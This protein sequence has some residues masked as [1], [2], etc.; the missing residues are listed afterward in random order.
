MLAPGSQLDRFEILGLLGAGG[1][2]E[3]YRAHDSRLR[4]DVA[5]KLLPENF[6]RNAERR[7]RFERETQV[8]ASLNHPNI[9]ALYEIVAVPGS[10]ALVLELVEGQTLA[11]RIAQGALPVPEALGIAAQMAMALEAAHERGIVHR[12][13]KSGNVKL[14]PDGT[15]KLLDF[16]LAKV[17]D[18]AVT[19]SAAVAVTVTAWV[20]R[21]A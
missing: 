2:G 13:L 18:P 15:V 3:V 6:L 16:G 11:E 9:A 17:F 21:P 8:L 14:R 10:H 1:M 7:A 4:R 20:R 12:D 19:D 5:L